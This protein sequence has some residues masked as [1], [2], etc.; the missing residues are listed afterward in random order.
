MARWAGAAAVVALFGVLVGAFLWRDRL[1]RA[2]RNEVEQPVAVAWAE[3]AAPAPEPAAPSP[4]KPEV[5]TPKDALPF[6]IDLA[7]P[8]RITFPLDVGPDVGPDAPDDRRCLRSRQG[9]NEFLSPEDAAAL[10]PFRLDEA[11][12]VRLWFRTRYVDD[13]VGKVECNNSCVAS[14][15]GG[16]R[17]TVGNET[18]KNAW[19]WRRWASLGL[20]AGVHWLRIASRE[21]GI[22]LDRVVIAAE[23]K[24]EPDVLDGVPVRPQS[25]F[26]GEAPPLEPQHPV[27]PVEVYALPTASLAI[28][29]GHR[30]EVTVC[31]LWQG[32]EPFEGEIAIESATVQDVTAKGTR[33]VSCGPDAP[34]VERTIE[35]VFPTDTPRREQRVAVT[36]SG[37]GGRAIFREELRFLKGFAWAF[38]GPFPSKGAQRGLRPAMVTADQNPK[39]LALRAGLDRLGLTGRADVEWKVV[40]D[41]SCYDWTGSVDLLRVYGKESEHAFAYAVTWVDSSMSIGRRVF[42]MQADDAAWLWMNGNFL[43]HL[44]V[45]LPREAN[46]LWVSGALRRGANPVAIR[47][48]QDKYYWGYRLDVLHWQWHD[49]R[50]DRITGLD[51]SQWPNR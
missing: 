30:N 44:P 46:R 36:V 35:L 9:A 13:G 14:I 5:E 24:M 49:R 19:G 32:G 4:E 34:F 3:P 29:A 48:E 1:S 41:G 43:V 8:M 10:Y 16:P 39:L 12:K 28:G 38:L 27:L 37:K 17:Q 23:D 15:D 26:A 25:G 11:A 7:R 40:D 20:D 18:T 50:G 45:A 2:V 33:T 21:D 42:S 47:I 6:A 31:A 22:M 51:V